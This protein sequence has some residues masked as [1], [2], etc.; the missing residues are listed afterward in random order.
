MARSL[1]LAAISA[2]LVACSSP[3][4]RNA[5]PLNKA[6]LSGILADPSI[7]TWGD[8]EPNANELHEYTES[9]DKQLLVDEQGELRVQNMLTISGGGANGAYGAGLLNGLSASGE[10]PEYRLVTGISTGAILGLYAFLGP[11]YDHKIRQ[12]YTEYSD[13]NIYSKRSLFSLF[14]SS[15][16]LDTQPFV[17]LVRDE[18]NQD[19]M[20]QVAAEHLRGRRFLVKT[21]NL[22]AQR[23]VIW[24]MGA[25]A[26]YTGEEAETLFENVII[27]SAAIPGAFEPVLLPVMVDGEVYDELHVDGGVMA[28]VFFIPE[29][30]DISVYRQYES[31]YLESLGFAPNQ[32]LES[33]VWVVSNSKLASEWQETNPGIFGIMGRSIATMLRFQ[34]QTNISLIERQAKLTNSELKLS[35]I[36][37]TIPGFPTDAPFDNTYMRWLYCY[38]YSQGINPQHWETHAPNYAALYEQQIAEA[39]KQQL[40]TD[41]ASFDWEQLQPGLSARMDQCL[42]SL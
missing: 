22:D 38:G 9:F 36:H 24:D 29:N 2:L 19:L 23:A 4:E 41:I 5:L 15:S 12:F 11:D 27:A 20:A 13:D 26:Q 42:N 1:A 14:S 25:I 40:A 34:T 32:N 37:H 30:L 6:A 35:Y 3:P 16:F 21:T 17:Q 7:R 31:Q 8:V 39:E 33:R 10:R 18:I 28:Q